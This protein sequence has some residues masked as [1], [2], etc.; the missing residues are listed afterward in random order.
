M[1]SELNRQFRRTLRRITGPGAKTRKGRVAV[2]ALNADFEKRMNPLSD[3]E[4]DKV[5]LAANHTWATGL[6]EKTID[7]KPGG[8]FSRV[9]VIEEVES[10]K[11]HLREH[12]T[13]G[14]ASGA[15]GV[16]FA[17]ALNLE[18]DELLMLFQE[19]VKQLGY[20]K[21]WLTTIIAAVAKKH[22]P[23]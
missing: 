2:A 6:P 13:G 18:N 20:P 5:R 14:S 10:M 15:D 21:I 1:R 22:K 19:C 3:S 17:R 11:H 8:C 12:H 9:F 23:G 7:R 4:F 16:D